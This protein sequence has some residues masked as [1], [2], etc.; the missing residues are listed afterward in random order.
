MEG[1]LCGLRRA[2]VLAILRAKGD[3]AVP[4]G[5]DEPADGGAALIE[6]AFGTA[7]QARLRRWDA[8]HALPEQPITPDEL[9]PASGGTLRSLCLAPKG[10]VLLE[11]RRAGLKWPPPA[12]DDLYLKVRTWSAPD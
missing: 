1:T 6:A 11:T 3:A 5:H 12:A 9:K 10:A 7:F 4:M 8:L 2:G